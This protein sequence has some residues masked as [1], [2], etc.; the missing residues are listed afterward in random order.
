VIAGMAAVGPM[1]P[2]SADAV[3]AVVATS[4]IDGFRARGWP[5]DR[6]RIVQAAAVGGALTGS[7]GGKA[8]SNRSPSRD[9]ATYDRDDVTAY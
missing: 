6:S 9:L 4:V 5:V 8:S 3:Q 1:T 7:V 2:S